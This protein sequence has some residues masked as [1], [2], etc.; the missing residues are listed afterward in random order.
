MRNTIFLCDADIIAHEAFAGGQY[1]LRLAAPPIAQAAR[2]GTFV[3]LRCDPA[4]PMRRPFSIQRT[5][6]EQGWIELLY[7][8]VGTGTR[9][10]AG[11]RIGE[12]VSV[13]GPIGEPFR[14]S[15][16][17]RRPLLLGGGVGI[18]PM[19]FLA[20]T[21]RRHHPESSPVAMMGS[22]IPFPFATPPSRLPL[23]GVSDSIRAAVPLLEHWGIPSRL[24]SLQGYEGCFHGYVTDLARTWLESLDTAR[25][26]EV[27]IFA[28]GPHAMLAATAALARHFKLPCQV[29][30]EE[31]MACGVGGCAGCTVPV[32]TP[33][34]TAMKRVCVDGPVFPAEQVFF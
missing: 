10:L 7:K 24:S 9:R 28:C 21:L 34:G 29:A 27:E 16:G 13:L 25:R 26:R 31:F 3:H 22:E 4:L 20:D 11:R 32:R 2:P 18:P 17:R 14:L 1:T 33:S 8:V 12:T 19:I 23:P 15:P 6:T 5:D 30:L